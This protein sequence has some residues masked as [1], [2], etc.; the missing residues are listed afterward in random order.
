MHWQAAL[1]YAA[2]RAVGTFIVLGAVALY[3]RWRP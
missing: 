2:G 1:A 3:M